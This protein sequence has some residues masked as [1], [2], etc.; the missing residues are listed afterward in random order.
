[1]ESCADSA[2]RHFT[3]LN[4]NVEW[5]KP[6]SK[7][8]A[9]AQHRILEPNPDIICLTEAR[10]SVLP[11]N[12]H[13]IDSEP[14]YG[15]PIKADRR[16]VVLWSRE[17]WQDV[18]RIGH[19]SMPTGRFVSGITI[20]A[21]GPVRMIG[22]CI[23]W[24]DAHVKTGRRDRTRWEDHV[25]YLDRLT[26]VL[27]S[28]DSSLPTVVVGDFN[29]RIPRKR[30][31]LNVYQKLAETFRGWHI[32][33]EGIVPGIES[34]VIDHVALNQRLKAEKVTGF[35]RQTDAGVR[36]SDH[37]GVLVRIRGKDCLDTNERTVGS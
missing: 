24:A 28:L 35:S 4:W 33:T 7:H 1:M 32:V 3:L 13:L 12:G 10:A 29:Q 22:V 25:A 19:P 18:D 23:S 21:V 17:P 15:Y 2:G 30:S 14:D 31:P 11:E 9:A 6:S 8:F 36:L 20:S 34:P 5:L 26:V 16:K 27:S 37:D